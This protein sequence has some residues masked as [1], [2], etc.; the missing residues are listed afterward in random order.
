MF[1]SVMAAKRTEREGEKNHAI[2]NEEFGMPNLFH[3][4]DK[5]FDQRTV[6]IFLRQKTFAVELWSFNQVSLTFSL[7]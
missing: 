4:S 7:A 2:P 1:Y 6:D 3:Q 5:F